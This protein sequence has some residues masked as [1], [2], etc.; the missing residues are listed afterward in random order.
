MPIA[1]P[2]E[3]G[4]G[5]LA[6]HVVGAPV[7]A[8]HGYHWEQEELFLLARCTPPVTAQTFQTHSLSPAV[9]R[10]AYRRGPGV[11]L[12]AIYVE[13]HQA[14]AEGTAT[15]AVTAS[16]GTVT[17]LDAASGGLDGSIALD[18]TVATL[19]NYQITRGLL[20]VSALTAGTTIDLLFTYTVSTGTPQ[21][22]YSIV[23]HEVPTST[24]S[25][26]SSPTLEVGGSVAWTQG[27]RKLYAGTSSIADGWVRLVAELDLARTGPRRH[28]AI[29]TPENTGVAGAWRVVANVASAIPFGGSGT[30]PSWR[31]RVP[32]LYTGVAA[33]F[34]LR[35]RHS[36]SGANT[37][38][39]GVLVTPVGGAGATT[40]I[41]LATSGG[42]VF[43]TSTTTITMP[44]TGTDQEV[45]ISFT[46]DTNA[47][48]LYLAGIEFTSAEP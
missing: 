34:T 46:S 38:H 23:V 2:R 24:V 12:V 18:A 33:T 10:I 3:P 29:N 1:V 21:G 47:G 30:D 27:D 22:I 14:T 11:Q 17:W 6:S 42:G 9:T 7:S 39:V 31:I 13:L 26:D 37:G 28:F 20:D 16:T 40:T 35:T 25:P 48:T 44:N 32:L 5:T 4:Y 41:N 43:A 36:T 15:V 45:D 8:S 19:S